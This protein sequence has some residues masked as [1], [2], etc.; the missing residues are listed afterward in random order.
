MLSPAILTPFLKTDQID[1]LQAFNEFAIREPDESEQ[2]GA[3]LAPFWDMSAEPGGSSRCLYVH[4]CFPCAAGD[5]A[6][7]VFGPQSYAYYVDC[8]CGGLVGMYFGF[9]AVPWAC[10]R[11]QLRVQDRIRGTYDNDCCAAFWFPCCVL[12]QE[13]NHLDIRDARRA[14]AAAAAGFTTEVSSVDMKSMDEINSSSEEIGC[15]HTARSV[16]PLRGALTT[17]FAK[18]PQL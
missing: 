9:Y 11:T 12:A 3:F 13:L 8:C 14:A 4:F 6:E 1:S 5:V 10:T 18:D 7:R 17:G 16:L 2:T 15:A